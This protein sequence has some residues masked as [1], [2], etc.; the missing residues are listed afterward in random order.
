MRGQSN[1]TAG[2]VMFF[3][4]GVALL[5]VVCVLAALGVIK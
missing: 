5:V 4:V 3:V 2:E 1:P